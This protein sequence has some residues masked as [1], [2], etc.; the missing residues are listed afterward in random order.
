[1][2]KLISISSLLG[3]VVLL[4][5][6][7][8]WAGNG[9]VSAQGGT[10]TPPATGGQ[11]SAPVAAG[12]NNIVVMGQD[13]NA[14]QVIVKSVTA[15]QNGWLLIRRDASGAPGSIIG[16]APIHAGVNTNVAVDLRSART[17]HNGAINETPTMWATLVADPN[18]LG[19]PFNA[20]PTGI[21]NTTP[22]AQVAFSSTAAG[23]QPAA[24][25]SAPV[26]TGGTGAAATPG[27]LPTT[28][29][30]QGFPMSVLI[31]AILGIL[32]IATGLMLRRATNARR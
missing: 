6:A 11:G 21:E 23:A 18:A 15:A 9:I 20:P 2:K 5:V 16:F 32:F 27:T 12:A 17:G 30:S 14:G 4:L 29:G 31:V 8:L 13:T 7:S 28:G 22:M 26:T 1:M 25:G 10:A 24:A 19:S 3:L